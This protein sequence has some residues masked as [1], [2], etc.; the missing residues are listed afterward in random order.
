M[1]NLFLLFSIKLYKSTAGS[2]G[3]AASERWKKWLMRRMGHNVFKN[4]E[5]LTL[6]YNKSTKGFV[7]TPYRLRGWK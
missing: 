7:W 4:W 6:M 2:G 1:N 5:Y 3:A